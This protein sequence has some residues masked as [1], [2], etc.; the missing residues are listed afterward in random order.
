MTQRRLRRGTF[1]SVR[2]LQQAICEYVEHHNNDARGYRWQA[3]PEEILAKVRR[4]RAILDKTPT[5]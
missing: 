4:A 5:A 1:T 2:Q 3:L